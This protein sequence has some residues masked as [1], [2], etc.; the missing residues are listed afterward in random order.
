MLK[1]E[2]FALQTSSGRITGLTNTH[3]NNRPTVLALHGWLDNAASFLPLISH[4]QEYN[5][6]AID[7]PGHGHSE[8]RAARSYY[9]FIDWISDLTAIVDAILASDVF[10]HV[11]NSDFILVGHS[12]G[13]MI[14]SVF[15]GLY[16]N[17]FSKL[18]LID[19]A[20]PITEPEDYSV[21]DIR[22]ALDSRQKLS[23][24]AIYIDKKLD[25]SNSNNASTTSV[26]LGYKSRIH[27]SLES[28]IKARKNSGDI[29]YES[30][31]MLVERNIKETENG[32]EWRIDQRLKTFSPIRLSEPLAHKIISAISVPTLICLAENGLEQ[33]K[34]NLARFKA[35]YQDASHIEVIG[36][37][38][39]HMDE[40]TSVSRAI[41]AFIESK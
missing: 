9:H 16:P 39:C 34:Q 3:L 21:E 13:G 29:S 11:Q 5:W 17:V 31:A 25:D 36:S 19:A 27:K 18:V 7:L 38:H 15:A 26:Q 37:H 23:K 4:T 14:S 22:N 20:G 2:E 35:D 33:V 28:A 24:K 32:F 41:H 30:A 1:T 8:H 6:I 40:V 10:S 12:M